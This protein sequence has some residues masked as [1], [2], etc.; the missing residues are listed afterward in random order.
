MLRAHFFQT[1]EFNII[2]SK[3]LFPCIAEIGKII[4]I[5]RIHQGIDLFLCRLVR[6]YILRNRDQLIG[7]QLPPSV[8]FL[9]HGK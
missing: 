6:F 1:V 7:C 4:L 3:N 9:C 5:H 8:L 2:F